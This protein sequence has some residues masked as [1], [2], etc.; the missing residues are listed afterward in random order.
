MTRRRFGPYAFESSRE[1]KV[2]FPDAAVSKAD[3]IAYYEKIADIMLP[4]LKKRPLVL[5]RFP[6]GIAS[7]GFIQQTAPEYFPEWIPRITISKKDGQITHAAADKKA[8]LAY[9]ADQGVITFHTLLSR[10]DKIKMPDQIVFDLDPH[11]QGGF[12][13]VRKTA[14]DLRD[15]LEELGLVAFAKTSGSRGLHVVCPI[16]PKAGFHQTRKFA[17]D[18][19]RYLASEKPDMLTTEQRK[20]RRKGRLFLDTLRNSYGHT[21]VAPY[22]LRPLPGAPVATPVSWPEVRKKSLTPDRYSLANIFRRLAQKK[23][24]W[25]AMNRHAR[26]L[27]DPVKKLK[28][29]IS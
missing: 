11:P 24:P 26:D 6:D 25:R 2:F 12:E 1:D 18:I 16:K 9:L 27:T 8:V 13:A 23:D 15:V 5:Q 3:V 29:L 20:K 10:A 21:L 17:A 28:M 19:A 7:A 14:L 4:Y 22:S